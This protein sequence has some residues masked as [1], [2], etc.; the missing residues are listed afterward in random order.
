MAVN[1]PGP[2]KAQRMRLRVEVSGVVQGVGFRPYIYRE[3]VKRSLKGWV[4]N[5]RQGVVMEVE[6]SASSVDQFLAELK[7]CSLRLARIN[8]IRCTVIDTA[9]DHKFIIRE[10]GSEGDGV[11]RIPADV[12]VCPSCREDILSPHNRRYQYPFTNCT[13]CGPRYTIIQGVPYD[14]KETTMSGFAMCEECEEEYHNPLNRRFHAQPNACPQCGPQAVL[15]DSRGVMVPGHWREQT[16]A[17]LK[18]GHILAV[19]GLGGFHLACDAK[20]PEAV[21]TLRYRKGRPARPFAVMCRDEDLVRRYCSVDE[22]EAELLDSP[23]AP[24]VVLRRRSGCILPKGLAPKAG[25]LGVM[26]PYTPLHHLLFDQDLVML[27]MTSGNETGLPLAKDTQEALRDIGSVADFFL[28]HNRPIHK[29][30]DDSLLQVI[31]KVPHLLRR[32]RGFVPASIPVPVPNNSAQ[33]FAAGGDIKNSF[34]FLKDGHAYPGPHIGDLAY[35]ETRRVHLEAAGELAEMLQVEPT[36]VAFD[37]HPGYHSAA[38][39]AQKP[40]TRE[41]VWHHHAHLASCMGE[42][43]LTGP[44]IGVICDG[45]G[46]GRDGTIW[47]GE[48]LSGDYL[49]F[50]R[51]FHL[52]PVPLPGGEAAVRHPWRMAVSWL[53]Q[54]TGEE[55]VTLAK[56]LFADKER[57]IDFLSTMLK[58]K[59]N[60]PLASSCGRLY[61]AAAALLGICRENTYDGQ[62]PM[63]LAEAALGHE[64]GTYPFTIEGKTI[65]CSTLMH[66]LAE[67]FLRGKDAGK[68]A[69][70]F[71]ATIVEVF[72]A[73]VERVRQKTGLDRVVLSGG[74]FQNPYLLTAL[75]TRLQA[76]GFQVYTQRQVPANDGG[77]ALGQA[78]VA[79]WRRTV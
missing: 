28:T 40:G 22:K 41:P 1:L 34:C 56:A 23:E 61:D 52:E 2:G 44:V 10:S 78:L 32:S 31:Q 4:L 14:R 59:V 74:S 58:R 25:T 3:A 57:E 65:S 5:N 29:R 37:C 30:C 49:D 24:I 33:V 21:Q 38:L 16:L 27:V 20:N 18:A 60:S 48:V 66:S 51:E 11:P 35:A 71:E 42:N 69:A 64:R 62:A 68:I 15:C 75:R 8:D 46:Y 77:L 76:A 6:G 45:T 67:D 36:V 54:S 39:A 19:K 26:L 55:G 9:D 73:A 17:L 50:E 7:Q 72:A 70:A 79:A 53:W 13:D 63:E 43:Y 47:G 12:A